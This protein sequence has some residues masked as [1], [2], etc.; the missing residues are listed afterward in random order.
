MNSKQLQRLL[1]LYSALGILLTNVLVAI[2]SIFPL[3]QQLKKAEERNLQSALQT[4][5]L[6]VEEFLSRAKDVSEQITSRTR[7]RQMLDEYNQGNV[8]QDELA[9]FTTQILTEAMNKS[10]DVVGI[11]R[12]NR[13]GQLISQVGLPLPTQLF[14]LQSPTDKSTK[15]SDPVSISSRPYIVVTAPIINP[16]NQK[17][18][19]DLVL[20][21]ITALQNIV[22]DYTGLKQTGEVVIGSI[23]NNQLN[24]FFDLRNQNKKVSENLFKAIKESAIYQKKGIILPGR[25][26]NQLKVI[27]FEPISEIDWGLAIEM[28]RQELYEPIDHQLFKIGILTVIL[29]AGGTGGMVLLLRPFT[30]RVLIKTDEL[31][32]QLDEKTLALQELNYTQEQLLLE[33]RE[34][35]QAQKQLQKQA[36][37]LRKQNAVLM[38]LTQHHEI[39]QGN[40]QVAVQA[41]TEA[42]TRTLNIERASV[43]LYNSE[44]TALECLDLFQKT[45]EQ[46]SQGLTIKRSDYP[47]YFKIVE[48][49]DI[50]IA[51]EAQTDPKTRE[52]NTN[53]L[54]PFDIVSML[55]SS[56]WLRGEMV[57]V[58]C[59]EQV[60]EVHHWTLEDENF[61]RSIAD[62]IS[63]A[64]EASDRKKAETILAESE[65]RFRTLVANIPGI[66]YR[67]K[68]DSDWT[69]LYLSEVVNEIT[70]YPA[71]DFLKNK[72]RS[73]SSLIYSE[74]V[75]QVEEIVSEA[76]SRKSPY[77]LEY[78]IVHA[79]GG[80][81]WVYEQGQAFFDQNGQVQYLDGAVFDIT[82]RKQAENDLRQSEAKLKEQKQQLQEALLQLKRT[83]SQMIQSE[84]MSS[85]G[86][87]VAGV[88]HEINNPVNFIHGNLDHA[89]DY[90]KDLMNLVELYQQYFPEPPAE[91]IE[92]L[93]DIDFE[94]LQQDLGKLLKS[95]R[96]GTDRIRD[97]VKSLRTFSRL[98]E[99]EL[100]AVNIHEGIDST[101][102]ILQN[103]LKSK[104]EQPEIQIIKNY[105]QLPLIHCY[106]GQLNQVFMNIISNG[107]DAL[108]E[109][110]QHYTDE[111]IKANPSQIRIWTEVIPGHLQPHQSFTSGP[112]SQHKQTSSKSKD[113]V[114]IHI[115][116]NGPGMTADIC[117]RLFDPFFTTKPIGKGTGLG[118]S[119]SYQ[120]V[121][122]KHG[123]Q[124]SCNSAPGEGAE[125]VIKIPVHS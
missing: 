48:T 125:F 95:M 4:R 49:E 123:G 9:S 58:L 116:D 67:C 78:R 109:F 105:G 114:A 61:V 113:W 117:S 96:V 22:Q 104:L 69:M 34:R 76:I 50:L 88:A 36:D 118:L 37:Q 77:L 108:E 93:K 70:G 62:I 115:A 31:E 39:N 15:V 54:K 45:L 40:L 21:K 60:S 112:A 47:T 121:V 73:F 103:R 97:I 68:F 72:I 53:Y 10:E 124:L 75:T 25:L 101:L 33:I 46:H 63:L 81:R 107:I 14:S 80:L 24:L 5:K 17:I 1:I 91:I 57:G 23:K 89:C 122:E 18:G 41:I 119:I 7:G 27:A 8:S 66:I 3:Y 51:D 100:K 42:T 99:A 2:L 85:L 94:F 26:S 90:T 74:D 19:T 29:I 111:E 35:K 55:D 110:D 79:N 102:M 52:F 106:P 12:F 30:G 92:E 86:Q 6:A 83:Q 28:N 71:S 32:Q 13:T 64:I 20:F 98:D 38:E 59:I 16:E 11:S 87:M 84:K 43:W 120:I 44:K 65:N 82:E 56:L